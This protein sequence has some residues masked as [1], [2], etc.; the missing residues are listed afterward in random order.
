MRNEYTTGNKNMIDQLFDQYNKK[1]FSFV[2][3]LTGD[4]DQSKDIVQET[5]IKVYKILMSGSVIQNQ[6]AMI[7]KIAYNIF[8]DKFRKNKNIINNNS[9]LERRQN[10][11]LN[12][13]ENYLNT[14]S[15]ELLTK[16]I[17]RMKRK[18]QVLLE[19]YAEDF[20]YKEMAEI[21]D[22]NPNSVGKTLART[23]DK[24]YK[25]VKIG[26]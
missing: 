8:I 20:S 12:P 22:M 9:F 23:I 16:G 10:E 7:F 14:E 26:D 5:F 17:R 3:R 15:R 4:S 24:L 11:M 6:K 25:N 2:F 1:T 21:I 13:E 19:L 18:E